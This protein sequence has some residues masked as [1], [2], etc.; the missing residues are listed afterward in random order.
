MREHNI[1]NGSIDTFCRLSPMQRSNLKLLDAEK[2]NDVEALIRVLPIVNVK[3]RAYTEGEMEMTMSDAITLEFT[4]KYPNFN[5]KQFPGYAH[6]EKFPFLKK[7]GWYILLTDL[8]KDKSIFCY[9]LIF[10]NKKNTEGRLIP[11]E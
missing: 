6:S 5:E 11:A 9:H 8:A 3:A 2:M 7:Q 4:I 1:V 10:R